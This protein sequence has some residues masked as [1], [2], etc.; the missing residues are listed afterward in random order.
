[1]IIILCSAFLKDKKKKVWIPVLN[2]VLVMD[3]KFEIL[4]IESVCIYKQNI[5]IYNKM[6]RYKKIS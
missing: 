1:M 6:T 4:C 3:S 5:Y 2:P